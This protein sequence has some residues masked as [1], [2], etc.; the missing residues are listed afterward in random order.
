MRRI[1]NEIIL[2]TVYDLASEAGLKIGEFLDLL[3]EEFSPSKF[4]DIELPEE[5]VQELKSARAGKKEQ[6]R[7]EEMNED[8]KAFRKLFPDTAAE[9][10]PESVWSDV[11]AGIPLPY[12]YA[13]YTVESSAMN[14]RAS[15]INERNERI[16]AK[17]AGDSPAE[18]VFSKE[19]VERMSGRDV[20]RNYKNILK[21]MK[22]WKY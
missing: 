17:A 5:V 3:E 6:K 19:Q 16:G 15:D 20:K 2:D 21:A 22:G 13:L 11:E 12:A 4:G 14:K 8:V 10:V 9:E 18:P 7:I 1:N